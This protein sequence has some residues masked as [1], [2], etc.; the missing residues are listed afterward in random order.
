LGEPIWASLRLFAV[1]TSWRGL[2]YRLARLYADY[3]HIHPF[4][5]LQPFF[6]CKRRKPRISTA[7]RPLV[8]DALS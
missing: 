4:R 8:V 3:N 7:Q 1:V 2:A 5:Y 6:G